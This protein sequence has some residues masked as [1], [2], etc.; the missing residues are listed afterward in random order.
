MKNERFKLGLIFN[1]NPKWM[2]GII[3]LINVVRILK[4][5]DDK[6]MPKIYIF[7]NPILKKFIDELDYPY[8]E[9]ISWKFPP[10]YSGFALSILRRKNLFVHDIVTKYNLNAVYPMH[11]LPVKSKL[12]EKLVPWTADVQHKYYPQFFTRRKR[13]ERDLRIKFLLRNSTDYVMYSNAA[14]DDFYKFYKIPKHVN[15]HFYHFVSIIDGL[16]DM[17]F[18]GIRAKYNLPTSWTARISCCAERGT[19]F[20][21]P[22][23]HTRQPKARDS[24]AT[25]GAPQMTD[26]RSPT[27][28]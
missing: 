25:L 5:L 20:M 19:T 24:N 7:Y 10:V 1:F 26:K 4:F 12:N 2:G 23:I 6:D 3:Y 13:F 15:F 17:D 21:I 11:N 9:K 8:M 14:K 18:E 28:R 22:V 27:R 16:P